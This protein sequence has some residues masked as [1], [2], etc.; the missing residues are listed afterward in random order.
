MLLFEISYFLNSSQKCQSSDSITST[1][2]QSNLI[3][4][5]LSYSPLQIGCHGRVGSSIISTVHDNDCWMFANIALTHL[6]LN[7]YRR[8]FLAPAAI[9]GIFADA[10]LK[11]CIVQ[12]IWPAKKAGSIPK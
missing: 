10:L 7:I 8:T 3:D 4:A 9:I 6:K 12:Y 2:M 5:A 11:V 1:N